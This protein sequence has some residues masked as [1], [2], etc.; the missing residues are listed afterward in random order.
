MIKWLLALL[1][2]LVGIG[3]IVVG[4]DAARF[5]SRPLELAHAR[6]VVIEPGMSFQAIVDRLDRQQVLNGRR[7]ALYLALYARATGQADRIKSG[8]YRIPAHQ[9]PPQLLTLLVSGRTRQ[10]RLTIVEGWRF[11][12]IRH[13]IA[14]DPVLRHRLAGDDNAAIMAAIGHADEKPEGRF[15]P[16]TYLFPRHTSDVAFLKRAYGA[17]QTFLHRA[18]QTRAPDTVVKT[19]YQALILASIIEKETAVSTE[20]ARIAGVFTRRLHKGM[21]LQTDPTVIYGMA[22]YAGHISRADLQ[23]DTPFNTY[24]R[25]GLPPTPIASP[26]RASI[27]AALHPAH[28]SALYFVARGDGTHVFSDTLAEQTA[29]VDEYQKKGS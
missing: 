27:R 9:T 22:D 20:R 5:L 18:W 2:V 7:D 16:D 19:P 25:A 15:L 14:A 26:S 21:R 17:M 8:E 12:Q 23:R 13:A 24:T 6:D 28:G 10:H 11:D 3:A 29:A 4:V 1:C